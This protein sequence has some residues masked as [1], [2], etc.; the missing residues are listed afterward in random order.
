[1]GTEPRPRATKFCLHAPS[2]PVPP[3][4]LIKLSQFAGF[5]GITEH[6][7]REFC[8]ALLP[9]G[10]G[11]SIKPQTPLVFPG[12][13]AH[14]GHRPCSPAGDALQTASPRSLPA[15]GAAKGSE[16]KTRKISHSE[17]PVSWRNKNYWRRAESRAYNFHSFLQNTAPVT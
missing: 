6:M 5:G 9:Q 17:H 12:H 10:T 1:M 16:Q 11:L 2:P 7:Q 15:S 8:K 3:S 4:F 14:Q 13:A